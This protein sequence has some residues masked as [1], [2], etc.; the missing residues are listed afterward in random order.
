VPSL[1]HLIFFLPDFALDTNLIVLAIATESNFL[2][3][4]LAAFGSD[5]RLTVRAAAGPAPTFPLIVGVKAPLFVLF[6]EIPK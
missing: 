1:P 6:S 4:V 5:V 2:D 3:A